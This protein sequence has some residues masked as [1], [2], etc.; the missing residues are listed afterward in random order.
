M[1]HRKVGTV[2]LLLCVA[3]VAC[4]EAPQEERE[5]TDATTATL[6][7]AQGVGL[8]EMPTGSL[9]PGSPRVSAPR[10]QSID[11]ASLG[12]DR[13]SA[14]A[15]IR[16][17]EMSDYGCGYCRRFHLETWPV[18]EEEFIGTG[19]V[20]WKFLPFVNGMFQN[21]PAATEAAECALEQSNE[22][23]LA[24]NQ[25]I[26]DSQSEWKGAS[27]PEP[28]LQGWAQDMGADMAEFDACISQGRRQSR[29]AAATALSRQA[30]VRGTPTFFIVG[31]Q[32]IQGA[33]PTDAFREILDLVY[34]D[35]TGAGGG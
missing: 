30:G 13:G 7:S 22:L 15:P 1:K 12:F 33:L 31:Y 28:L 29:V 27:A 8:D 25:R 20:Q 21:S 26:W 18:L 3:A 10:N 32:P 5:G 9:P 14:D 35:V 24:M 19:K 11:I 6:L 16:V 2:G 17:V 4:A 23:F 34:A